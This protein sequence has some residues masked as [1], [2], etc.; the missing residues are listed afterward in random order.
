D[1]KGTPQALGRGNRAEFAFGKTE[2]VGV[3]QVR[4]GKAE[5]EFAVNL[6]DPDES[7]IEPRPAVEVGRVQV[8]AGEARLQA[9]ETWKWMGA[10]RLVLLVLGCYSNTRRIFV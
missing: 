5:R 8:A 1:P 7:N 9:R 6:L 2:D 10:A 4:W 3:Y